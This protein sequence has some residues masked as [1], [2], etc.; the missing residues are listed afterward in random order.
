M[1]VKQGTCIKEEVS[2]EIQMLLNW[3]KM[4]MKFIK[5][6]GNELKA[7]AL[8]KFVALN[9]YIRKEEISKSVSFHFIIK[10]KL[11]VSRRKNKH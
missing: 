6:C 7:I 5:I 3:I 4:K 8:R 2:R 9:A 1:K 10:S 11:N